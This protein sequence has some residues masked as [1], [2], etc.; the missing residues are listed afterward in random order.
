MS[1]VVLSD[2]NIRHVS[3][4][5]VNLQPIV[6]VTLVLNVDVP[7]WV[8]RAQIGLLQ[9]LSKV[10]ERDETLSDSKRH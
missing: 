9:K 7:I 2:H 4:C 5:V 3:C 8:R 10:R 1:Q 6:Q